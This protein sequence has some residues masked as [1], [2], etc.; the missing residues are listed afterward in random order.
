MC[1]GAHIS[2]ELRYSTTSNMTT[3]SIMKIMENAEVPLHVTLLQ[4]SC[5]TDRL[6]ALRN[7]VRLGPHLFYIANN[8]KK[9]CF[10]NTSEGLL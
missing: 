1:G 7:S 6:E 4:C 9:I 3:I 5:V 2:R 8:A 10:L